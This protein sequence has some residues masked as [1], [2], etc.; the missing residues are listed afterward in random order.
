MSYKLS[1]ST[2]QGAAILA[3]LG[4]VTSPA[5]SSRAQDREEYVEGG[6]LPTG[7]DL[8]APRDMASARAQGRGIRIGRSAVRPAVIPPTYAVQQGDTLWD[9][10]QHFYGDPF[11]WP[12]VWSYNPE[13]TNPNWIYPL[14]QLRLLREGSA[15]VA[16][17]QSNIRHSAARVARPM[18]VYLREEGFLDP[19]E[20][21]RAGELTGSTSDHMLLMPYELVYVQYRDDVQPPAVGTEL[22]VYSQVAERDRTTEETGTLVRIYGTVRVESYDEE[23]HLVR[24]RITEALDPIERGYHIAAIP[25]RFMS[26]SPVRNAQRVETNIVATLRPRSIVGEHQMIF[27]GAG[28]EEGVQPGN[29]F[30]ILSHGD[31]WQETIDSNSMDPGAS[32]GNPRPRGNYPDEIVAE[33]LVVH[34]DR[35]TAAAFVT[36]SLVESAVGDRAL[37]REGY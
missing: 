31:H 6:A 36:N 35:H 4:L 7:A 10:T 22:S 20:M 18:E 16:A 27:L 32:V 34:V 13:I 37:M 17:P 3:A 1:R 30:F 11:E 5:P 28:A 29:R 14:D 12:R 19:E 26:V 8:A 23:E 33:V 9:I 25:R 24:A 21:E 15:P 2:K